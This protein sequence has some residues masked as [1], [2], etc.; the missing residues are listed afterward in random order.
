MLPDARGGGLTLRDF[1][2]VCMQR[3]GRVIGGVAAAGAMVLAIACG[4]GS[5]SATSP[6]GSA[7]CTPS[8]SPNTFVIQ[9]N[10]ICPSTMTVKLGSQVTVINSDSRAHEMDS[11]PHPEHTDCP[12]LNQ[13]GHLEPSQ[14]RQS[15]NLIVAR[16]C[17]MHDHTAPD[18]S[19]LWASI[20]IQ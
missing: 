16:T 15:G 13:I 14:S 18:V 3:C 4:G 10:T 17:G 12:E 5:S 11:D 6:T 19:S 2:G 1:R 8:S 9:N 20:V 7:G